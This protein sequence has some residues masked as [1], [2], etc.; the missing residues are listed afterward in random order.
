VTLRFNSAFV[1][2]HRDSTQHRLAG[3]QTKLVL[4]PAAKAEAAALLSDKDAGAPWAVARD[5]LLFLEAK[6]P[7]RAAAFKTAAAAAHPLT[8]AFM[9]AE[10]LAQRTAA[11]APADKP[12][13]PTAA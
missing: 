2:A 8:P 5:V 11:P 9:S 10:K 13:E 4:D 6:A 7:E 12:E 1:D 3:A